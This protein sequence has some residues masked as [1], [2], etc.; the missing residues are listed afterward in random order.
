MNDINKLLNEE[1]TQIKD[2][3]RLMKII[4]DSVPP[5]KKIKLGLPA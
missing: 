4:I 5:E 3:A 2:I 1:E